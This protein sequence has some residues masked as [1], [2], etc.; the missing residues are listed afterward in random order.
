M[1][2]HMGLH[3]ILQMKIDND[4]IATLNEVV[5]NAALRMESAFEEKTRS[6]IF[7]EYKEWLGASIDDWFLALPSDWGKYYDKF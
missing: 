1:C 5:S 3:L 2:I 4:L 7:E 6:C